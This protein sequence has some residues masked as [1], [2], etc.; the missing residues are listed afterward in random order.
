LIVKSQPRF[1]FQQWNTGSSWNKKQKK[2][3]SES[4]QSQQAIGGFYFTET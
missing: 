2:R 1:A 3:F 4:A